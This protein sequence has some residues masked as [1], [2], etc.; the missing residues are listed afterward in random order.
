MCGSKEFRM[1]GLAPKCTHGAPRQVYLRTMVPLRPFGPLVMHDIYS[2]PNISIFFEEF[3][4]ITI[5]NTYLSRSEQN[6]HVRQKHS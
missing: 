2:I 6:M 3:R 4:Y 5:T 1:R